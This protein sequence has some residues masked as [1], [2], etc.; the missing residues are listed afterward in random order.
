M[1]AA[2]SVRRELVLVGGGHTHIQVLRSLVM[3]PASG[4]RVTLVVDRPVAVY[5]GMVPGLVAGIYDRSEVE[6]DVRPLARRAGVRV[7]VAAC[8]QVDPQ[9]RLI[10][11]EGRPPIPYDVASINVGSTVAGT[12]LPGVREHAVSTRPIGRFVDRVEAAVAAVDLTQPL[13]VAIVG[14]GAGGIELAFCLRERLL[15][16]G[17]PK[18]DVTL[19]EADR[20]LARRP[21]VVRTKVAAAARARGISIQEGVAVTRVHRDGVDLADDSRVPADLT[22]WVVGAAPPPLIAASGLPVSDAGFVFV[23]SNLEVKGV[24]NLF[25][26]GDC[27]VLTHRPEIPKAGVYAVRQGPVLSEN[28]RRALDGR[29]L[30][31][32]RDQQDFVSLLALGDGTAIGFKWGRAV[33]GEWV[34]KIKDRIDRRFVEKFQVLQADGTPAVAFSKGMPVMEPMDDACGGCAAKVGASA[35]S[36][37]LSRLPPAPET[38][39]D[40]VLGVAEAD[41]VAAFRRG[42]ELILQTIDAFPAFV[43]DPWLVG[44]VGAANALS[45]M[46]A[47]GIAPQTALA[48]VTVPEDDLEEEV[49][50]QVLAGARSLLDEEGVA[51]LGGHSTV[52]P[53]LVVGFSV[54]G[55]GV[56]IARKGGLVDGDLLVLSRPLGTG[57]LFHADMAGGAAGPW[58]DAA[59][60]WMTRGNGP[61]GR[62]LAERGI[63]AATDVTGFAFA[64]HLNEM[65]RGSGCSAHIDLA[66]L[67]ALPGALELI[68]QGERSTFHDANRRMQRA[69]SATPAQ[70]RDPRFELLFDPQTAGPLLIGVAEAELDGLLVAL[71]AVGESPVVV[72]RAFEDREGAGVIH[73]R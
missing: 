63:G 57:V 60:R 7:V 23:K 26:A 47:K 20:V 16:D 55:F 27:A 51:L 40:V 11:L 25:A 36:A 24:P 66:T 35:L 64:G 2:P 49:L 31:R 44:R 65:L 5:S 41:D 53:N 68:R 54:T 15:R 33:E 9:R 13:K 17:V 12:D 3:K 67:P 50:F 34:M 72:G 19:I 62:V 21:E 37:A 56:D 48:L 59:T 28:L 6:L 18:V 61:G 69:V 58:I 1:K 8:T 71:R 73:L 45:D 52:G 39:L 14:G 10:H 29:A 46:Q 4:A 42:G 22:I 43:D 38:S 70:Q 30:R 32:Y